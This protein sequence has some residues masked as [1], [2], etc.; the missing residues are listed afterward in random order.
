[1]SQTHY[2]QILLILYLSFPII[3]TSSSS[4]SSTPQ[5]L[6]R[7]FSLSPHSKTTS[8]QPFL[9]DP[10]A[11]FSLGFLRQNHNHLV[12]AI[13]HVASSQPFWL[14]NPTHIASWS[15]TTHVSFNGSLVLSDPTTNL[16]WS[17]ATNGGD[18]LLLLNTSNLVIVNQNSGTHLWQSFDIPTN[19]L[20]QN[21]NFTTT[22][23]LFSPNGLYSL[24]L[25]NN[26]MGLYVNHVVKSGK[27]LKRLMY[28]K[29]TAL[30]AK[31]EI[32]EGKGPI[33]ARVNIAG[34]LGMYQTSSTP[35]DVQ[36][37][38][39]FQQT[40][41]FLML[42]LE[43]DGNL[44]GYYWTGFSWVVNYEAIIETCD[45]PSPCGSYG[46]CDGS[47]CECLDNR[48]RFEPGGCFGSNNDNDD[49]DDLCSSRESYFVLR[50]SGVEPPNKELLG[51]LTTSSLEECEGLCEKN[52]SCWGALYNNGTGFC[53]VL[54][55]PVQTMVRTGDG[56][57]VGYFKMRKSEEGK[58]PVQV[59]IVVVIVV[60]VLV[61]VSVIIG[62]IGIW[63]MRLK[64]RK[65][66]NGILKDENGASSGP[67]KNLESTSFRSIEMCNGQ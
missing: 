62:G 33:Y 55:Y 47:G 63:M 15:D 27:P 30:E 53:Y 49:D 37:F 57:K 43:P 1:M 65:G 22:M 26:F 61:A 31:A 23:S 66:V 56:S 42:R 9:T 48:T 38:N 52:C 20:V 50:R 24:G 29:R 28:W 2:F 51:Y 44:R 39:T 3:L 6:H 16:F 60:I 18:T 5:L 11:N 25:G 36:K 32:E 54:D 4:S 14:A 13:I 34:Y 10:T 64:R 45:L 12:L 7:G 58:N 67:Y 21:Q 35:V 8:F 40:S 41:S 19:T 59:K 17:T 46:L